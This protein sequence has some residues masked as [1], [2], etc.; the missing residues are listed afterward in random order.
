MMSDFA[1]DVETTIGPLVKK[2]GFV[3]D[4][5]DDG[6]DEGGIARHIV[7][8]RSNDCK[9]QVFDSR[10]EGEINCMIA[11]LEA[12]NKFGLTTKRWHYINR[13]S[14]KR[15]DISPQERLQIAIAE[16]EAYENQLE[17]VRDR[18]IKHYEAAHAGILE[19]YGSPQ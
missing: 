18:I 14:A 3:V 19:K 11:P 7:F 13:F 17:W 6:P 9:L 2:L 1:S 8:Y 12:P 4:E 5:I 15:T 16:A 10:R